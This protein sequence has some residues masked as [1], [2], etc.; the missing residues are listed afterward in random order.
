MADTVQSLEDSLAR[1][2]KLQTQVRHPPI[3][4]TNVNINQN[5]PLTSK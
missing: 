1:L 2:E 5:K 4:T 3:P